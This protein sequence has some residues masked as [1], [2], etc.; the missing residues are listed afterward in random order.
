[1]NTAE[2]FLASIDESIA[3]RKKIVASVP[4][5]G[6]NRYIDKSTMVM[7]R[8]IDPKAFEYAKRA[9]ARKGQSSILRMQMDGAGRLQ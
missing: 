8:F 4:Y 5:K 1:M 9:T 7:D 2:A 6:L 3:Q